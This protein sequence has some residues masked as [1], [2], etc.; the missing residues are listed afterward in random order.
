MTPEGHKLQKKCTKK[1]VQERDELRIQLD[2][3]HSVFGTSQLSHAQ[4]RLEQA[5]KQH[6]NNA[7][8][9]LAMY[10]LSCRKQNTDEWMEG[11][12]EHMTK[13]SESVDKDHFTYVFNGDGLEKKL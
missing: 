4:A 5:E 11:L 3:W 6:I 13:V 10:A 12:A 9:G 8:L 1:V 7:L 2:A